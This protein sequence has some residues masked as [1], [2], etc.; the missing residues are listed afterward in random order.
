MLINKMARR[1]MRK[2]VDRQASSAT[3]E[4]I[5]PAKK[6]HARTERVNP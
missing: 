6:I 4:F 3:D 2:M 1:P 5:N